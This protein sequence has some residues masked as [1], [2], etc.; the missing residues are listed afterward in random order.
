MDIATTETY[1]E[2]NLL[3]VEPDITIEY[4]D[5]FLIFFEKSDLIGLIDSLIL[6][7]APK[8][9][10]IEQLKISKNYL[11]RIDRM[12]IS[13]YYQYEPSKYDLDDGRELTKYLILELACPLLSAGKLNITR[14]GEEQRRIFKSTGYFGSGSAPTYWS[15]NWR[16]IW[17]CPPVNVD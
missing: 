1:F 11:Q 4:Y 13:D 10:Y 6:D 7:H 2:I 14:E 17:I 3:S 16:P 8:V 15:E 9:N 12:Y 5:E